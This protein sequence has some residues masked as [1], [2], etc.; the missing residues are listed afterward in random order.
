MVYAASGKRETI[1]E[2]PKFLSGRCTG[3]MV[4]VY[5]CRF[6]SRVFLGKIVYPQMYVYPFHPGL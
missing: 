2:V 3:L 4:S 6:Q 1:N 5:T